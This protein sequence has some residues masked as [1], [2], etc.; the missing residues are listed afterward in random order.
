VIGQV[1][2]ILFRLIDLF[3]P[4]PMS[5]VNMWY[6]FFLWGII[7]YYLSI[8]GYNIDQPAFYKLRFHP[9][10]DKKADSVENKEEAKIKAE[11]LQHLEKQK[12]FLNPELSLPDLARQMGYTTAQLSGVINK[13]VGKNFNEL[14]NTYRIQDVKVRLV[15]PAFSHL[16]ILGIAFESGFNSKATFNRAFKQFTGQTPSEF[17]KAQKKTK[18]GIK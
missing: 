1:I 9:F 7:I 17:M 2:W 5:Y 10:F 18:L 15:D 14:I 11:L 6:S 8:Y 16:S 12:P 4:E 3:V 13:E